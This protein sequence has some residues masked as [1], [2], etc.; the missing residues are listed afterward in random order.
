[1]NGDNIRTV[2]SPVLFS[3]PSELG[4]SSDIIQEK[5]RARLTFR[6]P[7]NTESYLEVNPFARDARTLIAPEEL[8]VT[9]GESTAPQP[10]S[11]L[12]GRGEDR[13]P[14][15]RVYVTPRLKERL[16]GGIVLPP[17]LNRPDGTAWEARADVVVSEEG[18]VRNVFLEQPLEAAS[19]QQSLVRLLY[20]LRFRPEKE[21][22][23]GRI[24][25]YSPGPPHSGGGNQ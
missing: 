20:G 25:I 15:R 12:P 10:P 7:D 24:E 5:L 17:E 19:V 13:L 4:F 1:V 2:W 3:L 18:F 21:P 11:G 23:S 22:V 14:P 6:Q 8:M 9:A 16:V